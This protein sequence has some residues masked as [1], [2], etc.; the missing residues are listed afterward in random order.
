[1]IYVSFILGSARFPL[2]NFKKKILAKLGSRPLAP[3]YVSV[4]TQISS[5]LI[6][7][8]CDAEFNYLLK[9]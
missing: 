8:V 3:S 2:A 6:I 1:M 4:Y 7:L 5:S 9:I